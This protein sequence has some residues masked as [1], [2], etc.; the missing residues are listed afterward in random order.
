MCI[1]FIPTDNQ[2]RFHDDENIQY[3]A[4]LTFDADSLDFLEKIFDAFRV[5]ENNRKE[6]FQKIKQYHLSRDNS[7]G[8]DFDNYLENFLNIEWSSAKGAFLEILSYK[9]IESYCGY[10]KLL[11]ECIVKYNGKEGIH[12]YDIIKKERGNILLIDIKF[13]VKTLKKKHLDY[14]IEFKDESKITPFLLTLDDKGRMKWKLKYIANKY[15]VAYDVYEDNIELLSKQE[16]YSSIL[17]KLC[18][19]N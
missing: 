15:N 18:I 19:L 8:D 4:Q 5:N 9:L 16:Y 14:L 3:F 13:T 1:Q 10:D 6:Y 11:K 17:H 7:I 2:R 12:P